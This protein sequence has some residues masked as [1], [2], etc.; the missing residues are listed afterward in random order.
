MNENFAML[1]VLL[2]LLLDRTHKRI[3]QYALNIMKIYVHKRSIYED[4]CP[5]SHGFEDFSQKNAGPSAPLLISHPCFVDL[6]SGKK[7]HCCTKNIF[8]F[9]TSFPIVS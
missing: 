6:S 2:V 9:H 3:F 4:F 8:K 5:L 7:T 1:F